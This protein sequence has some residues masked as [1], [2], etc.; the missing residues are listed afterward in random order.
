[1]VAERPQAGVIFNAVENWP[2]AAVA[3]TTQDT[4][5]IEVWPPDVTYNDLYR[6]I[7]EG[8]RLSNGKQVILAAYLS[9]FATADDATL[10]Q[11]EAAAFLAT[12]AIAASGGSH[13]LLGE[14]DGILCDPYYPKYATMRP[15]CA[16][17]MRA[18]YDFI[19]RYEELLIAP[20]VQPWLAADERM[21]ALDGARITA[22]A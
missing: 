15:G 2:I 21:I 5:Y 9:P 4:V 6:L 7:H 20:D 12:A 14:H 13:L 1:M 18:Y 19:V 11:A 3:P 17:Q 8:K 10:P 16:A 22:T